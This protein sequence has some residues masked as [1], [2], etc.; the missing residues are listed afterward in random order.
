MND[1]LNGNVKEATRYTRFELFSKLPSEIRVL[2]WRAVLPLSRVVYVGVHPIE[3]E[4][5]FDEHEES[6]YNEDLHGKSA[7]EEDT[8]SIPEKDTRLLVHRTSQGLDGALKGQSQLQKYGSMSSRPA[9]RIAHV[10]FHD[11]ATYPGFGAYEPHC[12]P[13][14]RDVRLLVHIQDYHHTLGGQ[15]KPGTTARARV[16][17]FSEAS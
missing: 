10:P 17:N 3:P 5:D 6:L 7:G 8:R 15:Q 11:P 13:A 2:I 12:I 9:P 14:S 4:D 16:Q 1:S